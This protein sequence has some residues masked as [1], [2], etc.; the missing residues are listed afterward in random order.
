MGPPK[1]RMSKCILIFTV[2]LLFGV[3]CFSEDIKSEILGDS[4]TDLPYVEENSSPEVP[5]KELHENVKK[6][7]ESTSKIL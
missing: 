4:E 2:V 1:I 5:A 6:E 3:G 7:T